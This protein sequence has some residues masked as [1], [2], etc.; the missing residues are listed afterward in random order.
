MIRAAYSVQ[1][2]QSNYIF[3]VF[4]FKLQR[5]WGNN[6]VVIRVY[7]ILNLAE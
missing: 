1:Y 6:V 7:S 2:E 5:D 4:S 3:Q